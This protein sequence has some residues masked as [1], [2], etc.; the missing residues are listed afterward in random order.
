MCIRLTACMHVGRD[1]GGTESSDKD[2]LDWV[3]KTGSAKPGQSRCEAAKL[4][5][6]PPI[7]RLSDRAPRCDA[8]QGS[9]RC[10]REVRDPYG[11]K[12]RLALAG[13]GRAG[14]KSNCCLRKRQWFVGIGSTR[15]KSILLDLPPRLTD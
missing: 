9:C 11:G 12:E 8:G 5:S 14:A 3:N 4:R 15:E 1:A 7:G 6:W 2:L 13:A 10:N